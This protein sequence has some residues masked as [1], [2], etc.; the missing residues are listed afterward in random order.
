[1]ENAVNAPIIIII[2]IIII[3]A[4]VII[5][6]KRALLYAVYEGICMVRAGT[7]RIVIL[8]FLPC[9]LPLECK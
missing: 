9:F 6:W 8:H 4:V 1:M 5:R 3:N 2:I 7:H